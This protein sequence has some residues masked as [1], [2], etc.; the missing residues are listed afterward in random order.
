[1]AFRLSI[2]TR[3][4]RKRTLRTYY[5]F[6]ATTAYGF[7]L[8]F[9]TICLVQQGH[10]LDVVGLAQSAFLFAMVAAEVPVGYVAD[11]IDRRTTLAADATGTD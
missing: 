11:R 8:P 4:R 10:G 3:D 1:M 7:S 5:L 6:R 9:S 2:H